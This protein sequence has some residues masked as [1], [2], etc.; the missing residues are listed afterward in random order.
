[1]T[2]WKHS[3][4]YQNNHNWE[5][6]NVPVK[7]TNLNKFGIP[8]RFAQPIIYVIIRQQFYWCIDLNVYLQASGTV[9]PPCYNKV[10]GANQSHAE[11]RQL[12]RIYIPH[13]GYFRETFKSQKLNLIYRD[14]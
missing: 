3:S 1:M 6:V 5:Q 7:I 9:I 10:G 2:I 13:E 11:A 12:C 14:P 4:I 8:S